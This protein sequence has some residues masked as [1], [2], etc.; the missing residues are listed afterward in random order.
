MILSI[1]GR[2]SDHLKCGVV[3]HLVFATMASVETMGKLLDVAGVHFSTAH[4]R[5][6]D[7]YKDFLFATL[8]FIKFFQVNILWIFYVCL[9]GLVWCMLSSKGNDASTTEHIT[10]RVR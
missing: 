7:F 2:H 4:C 6:C 5:N 9:S 3:A 10:A 1:R 8:F